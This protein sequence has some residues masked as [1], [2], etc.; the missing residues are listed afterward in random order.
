MPPGYAAVKSSQYALHRMTDC[1]PGAKPAGGKL[2][3]MRRPRTLGNGRIVLVSGSAVA[4]PLRF[5]GTRDHGREQ[6]QH[7]RAAKRWP[8]VGPWRLTAC[9]RTAAATRSRTPRCRCRRG[10]PSRPGR[11][12]WRCVRPGRRV[13]DFDRRCHRSSFFEQAASFE[14]GCAASALCD[15][16]A[17]GSP[18]PLSRA[19]RASLART[20]AYTSSS[21]AAG[22]TAPR[23][24]QPVPPSVQC[25]IIRPARLLVTFLSVRNCDFSIRE[26]HV[27]G[28]RRRSRSCSSRRRLTAHRRSSRTPPARARN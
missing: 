24:P 13:L 3:V 16:S 21:A 20:C 11:V 1:D 10:R 19:S 12:R 17:P 7:R 6:H 18:T 15:G 22:L 9:R 26:R 14:P 5:A 27:R 8:V 2:F 25:L 28:S 4:R 23:P